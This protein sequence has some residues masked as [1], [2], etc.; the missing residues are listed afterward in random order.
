[1][2][3]RLSHCTFDQQ[4][5]TVHGIYILCSCFSPVNKW[6]LMTTQDGS[7]HWH[8]RM[9]LTVCHDKAQ[10]CCFLVTVVVNSVELLT[11]QWMMLTGGILARSSGLK[12]RRYF[13]SWAMRV[14]HFS[15][16][17]VKVAEMIS[18]CPVSCVETVT[19]SKNAACCMF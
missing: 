5:C 1:V 2:I 9:L 14:A 10:L 8:C 4:T 7:K 6:L 3:G 19:N 13:C 12:P 16:V 17:T 15:S 18:R 11:L